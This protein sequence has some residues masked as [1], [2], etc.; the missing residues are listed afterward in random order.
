MPI[1]VTTLGSPINSANG[2]HKTEGADGI[3]PEAPEQDGI[4][5]TVND[6]GNEITYVDPTA[7]TSLVSLGGRI[8]N[9]P[10]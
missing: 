8:F 7:D 2:I 6:K 1:N 5:K 3:S 9:L 10:K 4:D